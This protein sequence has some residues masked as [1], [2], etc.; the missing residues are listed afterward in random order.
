MRRRSI[1]S[2]S[3]IEFGSS[4]WNC[5]WGLALFFLHFTLLFSIILD[6]LSLVFLFI[7][8]EVA[9]FTY[10]YAFVTYD[11]GVLYTSHVMAIRSDQIDVSSTVCATL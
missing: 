2:L 3:A 7:G 8:Y 6:D 10:I 11:T 5:D 1:C 4:I 9:V